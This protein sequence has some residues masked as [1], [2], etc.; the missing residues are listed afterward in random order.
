M[1]EEQFAQYQKDVE[2]IKDQLY[3]LQIHV[4]E[5][6]HNQLTLALML[7]QQIAEEPI[8]AVYDRFIKNRQK[9]TQRTG[10]G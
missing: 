9:I 8:E 4:N 5:L 7:L 3:S 1:T 2:K 10:G 6:K